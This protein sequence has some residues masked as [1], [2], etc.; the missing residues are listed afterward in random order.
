[1]CKNIEKKEALIKLK[2]MYES[3]RIES[4][5]NK[6]YFMDLF[7]EGVKDV[8]PKMKEKYRNQTIYGISFE[9]ANVVQLIY[10]D[11][12]YTIIYFN[13][14]EKY[15]EAS[16]KCKNEEEKLFYRFSSWAAWDLENAESSFFDK[17][18]DYLIKNSLNFYLN[19]SIYE[20]ELE[21]DM[22]S[23]YEEMACE[24]D[25]AHRLEL[26]EIRSWIAQALGELR[27]EG[28]WNMQ[29]NPDI[30]VIP[31]EGECEISKEELISTYKEIDQGNHGSEF[32]DYIE[33]N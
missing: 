1:M 12:Y 8:Y 11:D 26:K 16:K 20:K 29:G 32:L 27:S 30:Y 23:W 17:L 13:T 21:N 22:N 2:E 4:Q 7:K 9:I 3:K 15:Q 18:Q 6:R 31:F 28:F 33:L 19:A 25:D 5:L 24:I 10:A 14:E